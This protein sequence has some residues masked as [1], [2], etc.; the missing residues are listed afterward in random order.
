[1]CPQLGDVLFVRS[2][3]QMTLKS[4]FTFSG[5]NS[6]AGKKELIRI[7]HSGLTISVNGTTSSVKLPYFKYNDGKWN[8]IA[9]T[10]NGETGLLNFVVNTIAE[11]VQNYA[12]G[13]MI[14]K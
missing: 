9:V 13:M 12:K 2:S 11:D 5:P 14:D 4:V 1:M 3:N 6:L 10:W 7:D 8:Q